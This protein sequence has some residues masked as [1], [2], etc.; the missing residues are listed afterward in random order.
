MDNSPTPGPARH[1]PVIGLLGAPGSGKSFVAKVFQEHGAGVI[2]ADRLAREALDEPTV[3][4]TLRQW[5]GDAVIDEHGRVDRRAVGERVFDDP[6][7]LRRLEAVVHPRVHAGRAAMR[8][9]Y[10]A[11]PGVRAIVEDCP[12]LL[13][14]GLDGDCD[15]LVFVDAPQAVRE[16]RVRERRGWSSA[17]LARREKNQAS[18]D[19]KRERADHIVNNGAERLLAYEQARRVLSQILQPSEPA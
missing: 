4:E 12:L 15:V 16:A 19:I 13:E 10:E 3:R 14:Q 8:A 11:D 5:W 9:K 17:E 1:K 6:A 18:L 7:A 2:D